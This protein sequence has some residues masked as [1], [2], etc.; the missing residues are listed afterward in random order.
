MRIQAFAWDVHARQTSDRLRIKLRDPNATPAGVW[1]RLSGDYPPMLPVSRQEF[2]RAVHEFLDERA[3]SHDGVR[4]DNLYYSSDELVALYRQVGHTMVEVYGTPLDAGSIIVKHKAS[5][6]SVMAKSKQTSAHGVPRRLWRAVAAQLK[7]GRATADDHEAGVMLAQLI[8]DATEQAIGGKKIAAR[9]KSRSMAQSLSLAERA[10]AAAG[11]P[12]P[13]PS[14]S[15]KSAGGRKSTAPT[16]RPTTI[17]SF[18]PK[19]V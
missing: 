14:T 12:A 9:K 11:V 10:S 18:N 1:D 6:V 16:P 7:L 2:H 3:L 8:N 15:T 4:Y 5:G 19:A 13:A 17:V